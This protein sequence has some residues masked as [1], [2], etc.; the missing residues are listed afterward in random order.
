MVYFVI[1]EHDKH[2]FTKYLHQ[3]CSLNNN[4]Q[5]YFYHLELGH[6]EMHNVSLFL[7]IMIAYRKF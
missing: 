4:Y 5:L 6:N 3:I 1:I 2:I 7:L